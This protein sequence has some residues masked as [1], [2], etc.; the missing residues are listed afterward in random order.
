MKSSNIDM[1]SGKILPSLIRFTIPVFVSAILQLLYNAADIVVVGQFC[2]KEAVGAVGATTSLTHLITNLF[3]GLGVGVN[4]VVGQHIGAGKE[5]EVPAIVNNALI[6]SVVSGI[7]VMLIGVF[8]SKPLLSLMQTPFDILP[9]ASKYLFIIFLGAPALIIYNFCAAALRAYGDTKRPLIYLTVSGLVNVGLN[10]L[11]VAAFGMDVD[12]VALATIIS[13]YLSAFMV[14]IALVM[15]K[16]CCRIDL[17]NMRFDP[18][19]TLQIVKI[20]LPA[21]LYSMMFSASNVIV[22]SATNSFGSA[23]VVSGVSAASSIEGFVWTGM[24]SVAVATTSFVSQNYGARNYER[25]KK[26]HRASQLSVLV[27]WFC[28]A[29]MFF[30]FQDLLFSLYLPSDPEAIVY[31]MQRTNIIIS[32]YFLCGLMDVETGSIRGMGYSTITSVIS[33][34]G[35]C[36]MRIGWIYAVFYPLKHILSVKNSLSVLYLVYPVSWLVTILGLHICYCIILKR[37]I[38]A[39]N[40]DL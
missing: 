36:V 30:I 27:V 33:L 2:G 14:L 15:E 10:V 28:M 29:V 16:N 11:F 22:Q 31:G 34:I 35:T 3:I 24:N 39:K 26:V 6:L 20:G 12:G 40:K 9:L 8:F 25:I 4:V 38:K 32:I 37:A 21:G 13:Q 19:K 1:L 17:K 5:K 18:A 23:V 7:A